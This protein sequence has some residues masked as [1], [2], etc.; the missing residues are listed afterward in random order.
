MVNKILIL[1]LCLGM[2]TLFAQTTPE[3]LELSLDDVEYDAWDWFYSEL[4]SHK[5]EIK[6]DNRGVFLIDEPY[7]L[8]N[9]TLAAKGQTLSVNLRQKN[10]FD[11]LWA[12]VNAVIKSGGL[13]RQVMLGHYRL[14]FGRGLAMG[15]GYRGE[16]K[17]VVEFRRPASPLSYTPQGAAVRLVWHELNAFGFGSVQKRYARL[18]GDEI[19]TLPASRIKQTGSTLETIY[20]G[21]V[22]YEGEWLKLGLM[23]YNQFYDKEFVSSQMSNSLDTYSA[24]GS[25]SIGGHTLDGEAVGK[26]EVSHAYLGWKFRH[27][28]FRQEISY[29]QNPDYRR[30]LYSTSTAM[31]SS[32]AH[33]NELSYD[34]TLPVLSNTSL[35]LRYALNF[36]ERESFGSADFHS[37]MS[38]SLLHEASG[39]SSAFSVYRFDREILV[40][41]DGDYAQTLP[42]NWR[43]E[44]KLSQE[45]LQHLSYDMVMRYHFEDKNGFEENGVYFGNSLSLEIDHLTLSAMYQNWRVGRTPIYYEDDTPEGYSVSNSDRQ[46]LSLGALLA[47]KKL[48]LD[49]SWRHHL[50]GEDHRLNARVGVYL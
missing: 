42:H 45:L 40:P 49:I 33:S 1:I 27:G 41:V 11:D 8:H 23:S 16:V 35:R 13:L 31:L 48:R 7:T 4:Q 28:G 37:R 47:L 34:A 39:S 24:Y 17:N 21:G 15:S 6:L 43:V 2:G 10:E 50:D 25:L 19:Q 32:A 38:A 14:R 30:H 3:L 46:Y 36:D 29:S 26:D 12:N 5:A 44:M 22:S 20:G 9:L 18:V